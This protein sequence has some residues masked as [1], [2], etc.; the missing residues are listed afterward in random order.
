MQAT[1]LQQQ[2]PSTFGVGTKLKFTGRHGRGCLPPHCRRSGLNVGLLY[3]GLGQALS[4]YV[5]RYSFC[6]SFCTG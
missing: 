6:M 1:P 3:R 2:T 5:M 4:G